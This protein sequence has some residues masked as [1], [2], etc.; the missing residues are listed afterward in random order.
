[1]AGRAGQLTQVQ[2]PFRYP[3]PGM[4][5]VQANYTYSPQSGQLTHMESYQLSLNYAYAS[6]RIQDITDL[7]N[8]NESQHYEYDRW[9]R[10]TGYWKSP[11]RS[12]NG[13][14]MHFSLRPL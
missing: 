4:Q 8:Q 9:W 6:G 14:K 3:Y 1:M 13:A 12:Y 11:S 10:L 2:Y 7:L 5:R